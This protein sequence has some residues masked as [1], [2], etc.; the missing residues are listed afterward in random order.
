MESV[1]AGL[2]QLG[3]LELDDETRAFVRRAAG[4]IGNA[5]AMISHADKSAVRSA[6]QLTEMQ[7]KHQA[8]SRNLNE[9][10]RQKE[11]EKSGR[12]EAEAAVR[13]AV[14]TSSQAD[15]LRVELRSEGE[16]LKNSLE[17]YQLRAEESEKKK[18]AAEGEV[19]ML[20]RELNSLR[21]EVLALRKQVASTAETS[22]PN[23][24]TS[25][26]HAASNRVAEYE[27]KA[28][29]AVSALQM[30]KKISAR[31]I[32]TLSEQLVSKE[33]QLQHLRQ[34]VPALQQELEEC[35]ERA[36]RSEDILSSI[37]SKHQAAVE[38]LRLK[39][40]TKKR[41]GAALISEVGRLRGQT[42]VLEAQLEHLRRTQVS[43][44]SLSS[45]IVASLREEMHRS[46]NKLVREIGSVGRDSQDQIKS[47]EFRIKDSY[48]SAI[49]RQAAL[50][51]KSMSQLPVSTTEGQ[52][53]GAPST[54]PGT[55]MAVQTD[56]LSSNPSLL[57]AEDEL[58]PIYLRGSERRRVG[59]C[60]HVEAIHLK[61]M[62]IARGEGVL[63]NAGDR[64][65]SIAVIMDFSLR[66]ESYGGDSSWELGPSQA[67]GDVQAVIRWLYP[68]A[69]LSPSR[70]PTGWT[71]HDVAWTDHVEVISAK[72]IKRRIVCVS[73]VT[74]FRF[75][76]S[77]LVA[78]D[79]IY[80][81]RAAL[82]GGASSRLLPISA[83]LLSQ[84]DRQ[85]LMAAGE[86]TDL[87]PERGREE[88][89][90]TLDYGSGG[91]DRHSALL[92][93]EWPSEG[94]PSEGLDLHPES[95]L[96]SEDGYG[97][98]RSGRSTPTEDG[99]LSATG[100][101]YS[102]QTF[103]R[104]RSQGM[105]Y[106]V[107]DFVLYNNGEGQDCCGQI[108]VMEEDPQLKSLSSAIEGC[109]K[110]TLAEMQ[111][112]QSE[113]VCSPADALPNEMV[114]IAA[115]RKVPLGHV[116]RK[117]T[118]IVGLGGGVSSTDAS[119]ACENA[120]ADHVV[121]Y[122]LDGKS[123]LLHPLEAPSLR[124]PLP[125]DQLQQTLGG[126]KVGLPSWAGGDGFWRNFCSVPLTNS[127]STKTGS[128]LRPGDAVMLVGGRIGEVIAICQDDNVLKPVLH[129]GLFA[130]SGDPDIVCHLP[131]DTHEREVISLGIS[132]QVPSSAVL[133]QVSLLSFGEFLPPNNNR[134]E[135]AYFCRF[136]QVKLNDTA[137]YVPL[138]VPSETPKSSSLLI[139]VLPGVVD[140]PTREIGLLMHDV[141]EME[142]V[143]TR[144]PQLILSDGRAFRVGD[145]AY[146]RLPNKVVELVKIHVIEQRV[147][148]KSYRVGVKKLLRSEELPDSILPEDLYPQEL[149]EST[150]MEYRDGLT[151]FDY[152][153]VEV[154]DP[155]AEAAEVAELHPEAFLIRYS[156]NVQTGVL[157]PI[158]P[159]GDVTQ[160]EEIDR[161]KAADNLQ[162]TLLQWNAPVDRGE[163]VQDSLAV[164]KWMSDVTYVDKPGNRHYSAIRGSNGVVYSI[165]D[166][167]CFNVQGTILTGIIEDLFENSRDG[168]TLRT[169][170]LVNAA[171]FSQGTE[172]RDGK[173]L[174]LTNDRDNNNIVGVVQNVRILNYAEYFLLS[175]D[176][177]RDPTTFYVRYAYDTMRGRE[178]PCR[179]PPALPG[180][181]NKKASLE[182]RRPPLSFIRAAVSLLS[183][184]EVYP[185]AMP[186]SLVG[187]NPLESM[188][189]LLYFSLADE[190]IRRET[191]RWGGLRHALMYLSS[192]IPEISLGA[193]RLVAV[194][195]ENLPV[196]VRKP[197]TM[198]DLVALS[199]LTPEDLEGARQ[200]GLEQALIEAREC[201]L[202]IMAALLQRPSNRPGLAEAGAATAA[203]K[204]LQD[205]L[206]LWPTDV[207][208]CHNCASVLLYL[209]DGPRSLDTS[210]AG[211]GAESAT[212]ASHSSVQQQMMTLEVTRA[213]AN[214]VR[215][216]MTAPVDK[217]EDGEEDLVL[218]E[219][220]LPP[221]DRSIFLS[222]QA[223]GWGA[224]ST[225]LAGPFGSDAA[226]LCKNAGLPG[227]LCQ[228]LGMFAGQNISDVSKLHPEDDPDRW[229]EARSAALKCLGACAVY[230]E[231]RKSLRKVSEFPS[232]L[233]E[234]L[235]QLMAKD[236]A[237]ADGWYAASALY[238]K[239]VALAESFITTT[240]SSNTLD[241]MKAVLEEDEM[242]LSTQDTQALRLAI[243]QAGSSFAV[244]KDIS[245]QMI[246]R[247][248][249]RVI[250]KHVSDPEP[251]ISEAAH[252]FLAA[253]ATENRKTKKKNRKTTDSPPTVG[254]DREGSESPP[255]L[256]NTDQAA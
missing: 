122:L 73:E 88:I 67:Q 103:L 158:V 120:G 124:F 147:E 95:R 155:S 60:V 109:I 221:E 232:Q 84:L 56:P 247:H 19:A 62:D 58:C 16:R 256:G 139:S 179:W 102:E 186:A 94:A 192:E 173:E 31:S 74:A 131:N 183:P 2:V 254:K 97:G 244:Y 193:A 216:T 78:T 237:A 129:V 46:S 196:E 177:Q 128:I 234:V 27:V 17:L 23:L 174:Y 13:K 70:V 64:V 33:E 40:V 171:E 240:A 98:H 14:A 125:V 230:D 12:A 143:W 206:H 181:M 86:S 96:S 52:L 93:E 252:A 29:S 137:R 184:E 68:A 24:G 89:A 220:V 130:R 201:A 154:I 214:L 233:A 108:C 101:S 175:E 126:V 231:L 45:D 65:L 4:I 170:W 34:Q 219:V 215:S 81:V 138:R 83:A 8:L 144:V 209:A 66:S 203:A 136:M 32:D 159:F 110:V 189:V 142:R 104:V 248:F 107:G 194:L 3:R 223:K 180:Q 255:P 211:S 243:M 249:L 79:A 241:T 251:V 49:H 199:T 188:Q 167:V 47:L 25:A 9:V 157:I 112:A 53:S 42:Q 100:P 5:I 156:W 82:D 105:T 218:D 85:A 69:A 26:L 153:K 127:L 205:A 115:V 41:E 238:S 187:L 210:L 168:H 164:V 140:K 75:F 30:E 152:A 36:T 113:T 182:H 99:V 28:R 185:E 72:C 160:Q 111:P 166:G 18:L 200:V 48:E 119:I 92:D 134:D 190:F 11:T 162:R 213:L 15:S 10:V 63:V 121:R 191:I 202:R 253:I 38:D 198:H 178:R 208:L 146:D 1:Q 39:L 172:S 37:E 21:T 151:L 239:N 207:A 35:R 145:S 133:H 114:Y 90:T 227:I 61:G 148:T 116:L 43:G 235:L 118:V 245:Q 161:V 141:E 217:M 132:S 222:A 57:S 224:L 150:V 176:K 135:H 51:A 229:I 77:N 80:V 226:K 204:S 91:S 54:I 165:G 7:A 44:S 6:L 87:P 195:V 71:D 22:Q 246:N 197:G 76:R 169:R 242:H 106:V 228:V 50:A 20:T 55:P 250:M 236:T 123:G 149:F 59:N 225:L 163:L 117:L 212:Q